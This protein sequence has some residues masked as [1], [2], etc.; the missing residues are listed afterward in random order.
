MNE[1]LPLVLEWQ[2]SAPA[3]RRANSDVH[4]NKRTCDRLKGAI[5]L[6]IAAVVIGLGIRFL[7]DDSW[8]MSGIVA[9]AATVGGLIGIRVARIIGAGMAARR[10]EKRYPPEQRSF[11][12]QISHSGYSV[13]TPIDSVNLDWAAISRVVETG[14]FFLLYVDQSNAHYIPKFGCD[15]EKLVEIRTAFETAA[16]GKTEL[17]LY[18]RA[19]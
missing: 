7:L 5:A 10:K 4:R 6:I 16:Q 12:S 9:L 17:S 3:F 1:F 13:E 14:Q 11:V 8:A 15:S 19:A 18:A 2:F